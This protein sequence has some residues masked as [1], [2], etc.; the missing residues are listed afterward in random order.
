MH[1][2][3]AAGGVSV[4]Q[5]ALPLVREARSSDAEEIAALLAEPMPGA[6]RLVLAAPV[7]SCRPRTD[8]SLRHHAVVVRQGDGPL[9]GYGARTVRTLRLAGQAARVGYLHGLRRTSALAGHGRRLARALAQLQSARRADEAAHDFTAIL[10]DNHRAR[11]VLEGGLPGAPAYHLLADY[12]TCVLARRSVASWR[13][14]DGVSVRRCPAEAVDELKRMLLMQ[15]CAYAPMPQADRSW[16]TAW[17]GSQLVGATLLREGPD[18]HRVLVHGYAPWLAVLR[19]L[20]NIP[21]RWSGRPAFPC[22]GQ[23]L[24]LGFLSHLTLL[25]ARSDVLRAL[26]IGTARLA[27]AGLLV[28]GCGDAHPLSSLQRQVPG[29]HLASRIYTVGPRPLPETDVVSPEAA[30]L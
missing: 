23:P 30:W 11:R 5:A 29:W 21:L 16:I 1:G 4:A 28:L 20:I 27:Q 2:R 18:L 3:A 25:E 7:E 10:S 6:M 26:L 24:E 9:Q 17:R 15:P 19:P 13:A 8:A 12:R 14:P 22:A